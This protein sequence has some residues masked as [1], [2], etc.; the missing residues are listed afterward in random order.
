MQPL[1][2]RA[3]EAKGRGAERWEEERKG[4]K[5]ETQGTLAFGHHQPSLVSNAQLVP[6]TRVL[7][8]D[9]LS[10]ALT[11][12]P[13]GLSHQHV[14]QNSVPARPKSTNCFL[15]TLPLEAVRKTL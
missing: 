12:T 11:V 2:E 6:L 4:E 13:S 5:S 9:F 14:K 7:V 3:E 8:P 1:H 15:N 10:A